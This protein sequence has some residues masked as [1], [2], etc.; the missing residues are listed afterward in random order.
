MP[1]IKS[2]KCCGNN[3]PI[4]KKFGYPTTRIF[5]AVI[6]TECG[7]WTELHNTSDEAIKE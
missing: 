5:W 3:M 6:C 1:K 2:C 4:A 7:S